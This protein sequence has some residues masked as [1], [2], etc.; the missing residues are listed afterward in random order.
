MHNNLNKIYFNLLL[1]VYCAPM[2]LSQRQENLPRVQVLLVEIFCHPES[3]YVSWLSEK[4]WTPCKIAGHH[5]IFPETG[6]FL[7]TLESFWTLW[8]ISGHSGKFPDSLESFQKVCEFPDTLESFWTLWKTFQ[9]L[10]KGSIQFEKVFRNPR[11]FLDNL[12]KFLD[13]LEI[14]RTLWKAPRHT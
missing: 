14:R 4:I 10:L 2:R 6:K 13:T 1:F 3:F 8:N 12:K 5:G 7:D 11:M 9:P